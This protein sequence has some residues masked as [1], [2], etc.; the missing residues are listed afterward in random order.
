MAKLALWGSTAIEWYNLSTKV[1]GLQ[2]IITADDEGSFVPQASSLAYLGAQCP[3]LSKPY[4]VSAFS[5]SAKRT[6]KDARCHFV[7]PSARAA[8]YVQLAPGLYAPAPA[9]A[10]LQT[11]RGNGLLRA[12]ATGARLCST[13]VSAEGQ[14]DAVNRPAPLSIKDVE[15]AT[16]VHG[17][18]PGCAVARRALPWLLE[19]AASPREIALGLLMSLP[20]HLGG[21]AF[22]KPQL[23]YRIELN[24]TGSPLARKGFY[25]ADACWSD[26]RLIL[27]YDSD[28]WHLTSEQL[29]EDA[30]KR[31]ALEAMG[32]RVITVGR[33][34]MNDP[35][36]MDR[37]ALAVARSLGGP[38]RFRV[39]DFKEK[40]ALL[41][42]ELG[43]FAAMPC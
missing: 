29:R 2:R 13:F 18:V 7:A 35:A 36:E 24:A 17:D 42:K 5:R 11:C 23:N 34:Q 31:M 32:Y 43:L 25:V 39:A 15:E 20:N 40:Q 26:A 37:V 6:L 9:L 38:V 33:L 14:E 22:P 8:S 27:E 1:P 21:Y 19:G 30:V 28:K 41:R 3:A 12:I 4:H 10:Y 16:R